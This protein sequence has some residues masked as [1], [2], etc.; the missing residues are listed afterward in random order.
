MAVIKAFKGMRYNTA[1]AGEISSLC[2]PPYDIISEQERLAFIKENEYNI[3]RLELP[4][5]GENPYAC[6]RDILKMWQDKGILKIEDKPAIYIY[7]EEFSVGNTRKSIKG[8]IARVQLEE[9]SKGIILPHEFTLSK[10][11]EDRLNLMKATNCNFSQIYALYMDEKHTTLA[12]IDEQSK[13]KADLE[14]TDET[15]VTHRLWI[16]T[17]EE[18]IAK[19]VADFADRKLYIADGHHRYETALNYRNYCRENGISK[20]GD[21]QDFQM[22]Y[23]VDME[24]PGLVVFPTHRLVRDLPN[25]DKEAVLEK[26]SE[27]FYIDEKEGT[28]TMEEDLKK[29]YDEGKKAFGFYCG[30]GEWFLLTLKNIDFMSQMLPNVSKASQSLDVS[31]LHTLILEKIF[32][33]DKENMAKQINLTYTKFFTEAIDGVDKGEFQCSFVLNP[34]RVTEIRDV[35]A[36][37]EKMPQKSTYFYPKMITGMVMNNLGVD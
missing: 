21:P 7:E 23:L 25:F 10:A 1:K 4:K 18:I 16:E 27:F 37:G 14:F 11:K 33:I 5:E 29:L 17:D 32:G 28:D 22:I 19:L 15:G 3:I 12:T 6:A 13:A 2:C 9:F 8:I 24:H 26:C 35:A 36:A 31:V 34:T 20:P 30:K